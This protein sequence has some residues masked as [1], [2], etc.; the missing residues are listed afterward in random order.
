MDKKVGTHMCINML[1]YVNFCVTFSVCIT[2]GWS[3]HTMVIHEQQ[4]QD[5]KTISIHWIQ[6]KT[7]GLRKETY[8]RNLIAGWSI[9]ITIVHICQKKDGKPH[10]SIENRTTPSTSEDTSPHYWHSQ[11]QPYQNMNIVWTPRE[12]RSMQNQY[13]LIQTKLIQNGSE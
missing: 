13:E 9:S 10:N 4:N 2:I 6:N 3:S 7:L 1:V 11:Q 5:G 12:E 8:N